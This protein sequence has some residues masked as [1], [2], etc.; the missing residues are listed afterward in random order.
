MSDILGLFLYNIYIFLFLFH[1]RLDHSP[2]LVFIFCFCSYASLVSCFF[3]FVFLFPPHSPLKEKR[4]PNQRW[5]STCPSCRAPGR[6]WK[7]SS[8]DT[9]SV[10]LHFYWDINLWAHWISVEFCWYT[11]SS[12]TFYWDINLWVHWISSPC[13]LQIVVCTFLE[14]PF[15]HARVLACIQVHTFIG[16]K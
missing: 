15:A 11:F 14:T 4:Q 10:Q 2:I 6:I 7:V 5:K 9:C 16:T 1:L 8:V 12:A 3:V 13:V